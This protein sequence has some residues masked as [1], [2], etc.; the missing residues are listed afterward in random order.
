MP[1]GAFISSRERMQ[2]LTHHP[3]L[4]HITTFGGHPVS[5]AAALASLDILSDAD[6]LAGVKQKEAL[7]RALLKHP[8]IKGISGRGLMLAVHL[9]NFETVH[10]LIQYGLMHGFITD[11]F[12]F[13]S[14]A[15]RLAPALNIPEELILR[16][17]ELILAGLDSR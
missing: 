3:Y 8:R 11:W 17:C 4:G 7:F 13:E 1:L 6:L 10:M 15:F 5:C 12:L 9:E 14:S 2:L 16:A